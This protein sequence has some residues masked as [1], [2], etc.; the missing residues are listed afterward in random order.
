MKAAAVL[1]IALSMCGFADIC[2]AND[3]AVCVCRFVAPQYSPI[4]RN[5]VI[6]GTV[7]LKVELNGDGTT[8][9]VTILDETHRILGESAEAAVREWQF[10]LPQMAKK[11]ELIITVQFVLQGKPAEGWAPTEVKFEPSGKVTITAPSG[12]TTQR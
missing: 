12:A 3:H 11:R 1:A 8:A 5:A 7:H 10:C 2:S 9:R 4:A 6:Q